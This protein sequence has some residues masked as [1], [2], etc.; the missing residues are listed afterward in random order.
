LRSSYPSKQL[1]WRAVILRSSYP[2]QLSWRTVTL[3]SI[4]PKGAELPC[5]TVTLRSS[6][7]SKQATLEN[8]YTEA[9]R[10]SYPSKQ[11]PWRAVTPECPGEGN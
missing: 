4:Y 9:L 6:Y 5:R 7:P 11:L 1:P 3:R 2:K 10:S 8:R